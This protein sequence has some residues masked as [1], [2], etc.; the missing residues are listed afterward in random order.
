MLG[1]EE[2]MS[3]DPVF[4]WEINAHNGETLAAFYEQVFGWSANR[5]DSGF[6]S[7]DSRDKEGRGIAGGI[8]TGKGQLPPHRAL[9]VQVDSAAE[10][11][12]KVRG[13]GGT[14]LLEPF[15]GPGGVTLAF[16]ED[17]EGHVTGLVERRKS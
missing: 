13:A 5:D 16:F 2:V 8:F 4:F 9:Y 7:I 12:D 1:P 11:I 15:E 3:A 6:H 14:V 17:L 10:T